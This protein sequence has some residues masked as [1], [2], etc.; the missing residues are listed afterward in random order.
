MC[1]GSRWLRMK[2]RLAAALL[3]SAA[4]LVLSSALC[5]ETRIELRIGDT[6]DRIRRD[7]PQLAPYLAEIEKEA[8]EAD[9]SNQDTAKAWEECKRDNAKLKAQRNKPRDCDEVAGFIGEAQ[10][11]EPGLIIDATLAYRDGKV[12]FD[13]PGAWH[14]RFRGG[15]EGGPLRAIRVDLRPVFRDVPDLLQRFDELSAAAE[16]L[17]AALDR[18]GLEKFQDSSKDSR[19]Y[20]G[21]IFTLKAL[22]RDL[23]QTQR[24]KQDR[25]RCGTRAH[26]LLGAWSN[27]EIFAMLELTRMGHNA[28]VVAGGGEGGDER[29]YR[30]AVIVAD[31]SRVGLGSHPVDRRMRSYPGNVPDRP[32]CYKD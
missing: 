26:Y 31:N 9:Q 1:D 19:R 23:A 5:A 15:F 3:A 4:V 7:I 20:N 22:Q 21:R 27:D 28:P 6:A 14:L 17:L 12:A 24:T 29:G 16:R 25:I 8:R 30:L 11:D 18:S 2:A 13:V 32:D 10:I